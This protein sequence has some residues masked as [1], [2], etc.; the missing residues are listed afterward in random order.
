MLDGHSWPSFVGQECPTLGGPSGG[1]SGGQSGGDQP[2]EQPL[3][4]AIK[5]QKGAEQNLGTGKG[6]AGQQDAERAVA[7]L[8]RA[9]KELEDERRRIASLPPEHFEKM[10]KEQD[11]TADKTQDLAKEMA[12]VSANT[13]LA[14]I[15]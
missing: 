2:G 14:R 3:R 5:D 9:L 11:Q 6:K 7:N 4:D 10:A 12:D 15:T 8:K 13:C 1:Q